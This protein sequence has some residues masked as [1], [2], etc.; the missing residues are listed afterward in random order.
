MYDNSVKPP[1]DISSQ[2]GARR[3]ELGLSLTQLARRADTSPATLSRYE[4]GW[5]R[6]EVSTLRKL[7]TALGCDLVVGLKPKER[8]VDQPRR[9]EVVH[10]LQRLFWDQDLNA[11][12]LDENPLWVVERVLEYGNLDDVHVLV[13][14]MGREGFLRHVSEARF[15]S[16]RTRVFWQQMLSKEGLT[17]TRKFSR[18]EAAKSWQSS[19]LSIGLS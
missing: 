7:A 11:R 10:R 13:G 1:E 2:I 9:S 8:R 14:L 12:H 16:D 6:F 15:S 4:N 3:R 5:S 19:S 17:C 18:E